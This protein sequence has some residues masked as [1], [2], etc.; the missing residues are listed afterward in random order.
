MFCFQVTNVRPLEAMILVN[1]LNEIAN[2]VEVIFKKILDT[3]C[4]NCDSCSCLLCTRG[5]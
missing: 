3:N 1:K 2:N 4:Y 5:L